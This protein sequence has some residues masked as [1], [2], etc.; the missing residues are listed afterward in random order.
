MIK[1]NIYIVPESFLFINLVVREL[2]FQASGIEW[3][4]FAS[5]NVV[6]YIINLIFIYPSLN[7]SLKAVPEI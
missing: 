6:G 1:I 7:K 2:L 4:P 5:V 3:T